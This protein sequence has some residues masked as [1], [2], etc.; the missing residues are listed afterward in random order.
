MTHA[1]YCVLRIP[2]KTFHVRWI[3]SSSFTRRPVQEHIA[4]FSPSD[5]SHTREYIITVADNRKSCRR[6]EGEGGYCHIWAIFVRAAVKGTD[7]RMCAYSADATFV[8][9]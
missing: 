7:S 9:L 8:A 2:F 1:A 5:S 4:G 6:L 3:L